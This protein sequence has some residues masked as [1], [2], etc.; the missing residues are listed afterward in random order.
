MQN[1]ITQAEFDELLVWLD[2]DRD[3]AGLKYEKIRQSLL[4]LFASRGVS[5][6]EDLAD[7]TINRVIKKVSQ[8][9][10]SYAGDQSLYFYGVAKRVAYEAQRQQSIRQ[11]K[12][13]FVP[14]EP[15]DP[16]ELERQMRVLDECLMKLP[17]DDR[18]LI[19]MYYMGR[20]SSKIHIRKQLGHSLRLSQDTMRQRVHRLKAKLRTWILERLNEERDSF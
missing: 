10:D 12:P 13:P 4:T 14:N 7:E 6:P 9:K 1:P 5:D 11:V 15:M 18:H 3:K 19:L 16:N 20:G 17:I 8:L 2:S